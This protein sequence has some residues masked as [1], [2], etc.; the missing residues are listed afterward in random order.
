MNMVANSIDN[1]IWDGSP[2]VIGNETNSL[3]IPNTIQGDMVLVCQNLQ[4]NSGTQTIE[5]SSGDT[6]LNKIALQAQPDGLP[7]I[8][9]HNF[10]GDN[11]RIENTTETGNCVDVNIA[12]VGPGLTPQST[13]PAD[14]SKHLLTPIFSPRSQCT[15]E[16]PYT[17]Q[18]AAPARRASLIFGQHSSNSSAFVVFV[19]GNAKVYGVNFPDMIPNGYTSVVPGNTNTLNENWLGATLTIGNVSPVTS[20]E[21]F[22]QLKS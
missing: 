12:A 21:S 10:K 5:I 20:G 14:S 16:Q 3:N 18:G 2:K 17:R 4:A 8:Y 6:V 22:V 1:N 13:L 11:C 19:N 9:I 7:S 15:S